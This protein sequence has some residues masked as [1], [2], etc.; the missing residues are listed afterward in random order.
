[1]SV[2]STTAGASSYRDRALHSDGGID[3]PSGL[4]LVGV[5][6]Q[7]CSYRHVLAAR[8]ETLSAFNGTKEEQID[9]D[10]ETKSYGSK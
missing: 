7:S 4:L 2:T 9:R 1:M 3:T 10:R 6:H 5:R 8:I